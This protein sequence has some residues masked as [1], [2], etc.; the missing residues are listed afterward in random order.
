MNNRKIKRIVLQTV[1]ILLFFA[2]SLS[3]ICYSLGYFE[4]PY[5]ERPGS[6]TYYRPDLGP[7]EESIKGV[8]TG[9]NIS[10][11]GGDVTTGTVIVTVPVETTN[12]GT[13][14]DD[15]T[16]PVSENGLLSSYLKKG[17]KVT[18]ADYDS[19]TKLATV[20]SSSTL[21]MDETLGNTKEIKAIDE[22]TYEDDGVQFEIE[23]I[24]T[25]SRSAVELYMGFIIVDAGTCSATSF[26]ATYDKDGIRTGRTS[27][28]NVK[29]VSIYSSTGSF[30]GTYPSKGLFLAYTRDTSDRALFLIDDVYY[31]LDETSGDFVQSDYV[32]ER[33]NRGLY[34]DYAPNYGK[35]DNNLSIW[36][37]Y[38]TVTLSDCIDTAYAY[39]RYC[40]DWKLAREIYLAN[41]KFAELA[42]SQYRTGKYYNKIFSDILKMEK[43]ILKEEAKTSTAEETTLPTPEETTEVISS[44][45]ITTGPEETTGTD[46]SAVESSAVESSAVESSA[47]ES[48][49]VESSA[50]ESSAVDSSSVDSSAVE[51][52]ATDSSSITTKEE[53]TEKPHVFV[54][55]SKDYELY[56]FTYA[57]KM[58]EVDS[59]ATTTVKFELGDHTKE[60]YTWNSQYKYAKAFNFSE[61]RA[62]T[63]D[64][65]GRIR[66]LKE[67]LGTSVY[68]YRLYKNSVSNANHW[69]YYT[70][71]F[72]KDISSLG[73]YYYD[74]GLLRVRHVE[75]GSY[76]PYV[77]VNDE[78]YLIDTSGNRYELPTGYNLVNYSEG[79]LIL[80]RNGLYGCYHKD[81][82]WIAQPVYTSAEP[83][84]EGL[85]VLTLSD[86]TK[87]MIDKSGNVVIPFRYTVITN[88]SSGV[89]ATYSKDEGWTVLAKVSK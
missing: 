10:S 83:F 24:T 67:N 16:E 54:N 31:Y 20:F 52:S 27:I 38:E 19:G 30:I 87:G 51:S 22:L 65:F 74:E 43:A 14:S 11:I 7:I 72:Y 88:A 4:L 1:T 76:V 37:N 42:A 46:S 2:I 35:S 53:S 60:A 13:P 8:E 3:A 49:A 32:D 21:G 66:I 68:L 57:K 12:G 50:V 41:S 59:S 15:P 47:V 84:V 64:D 5:I 70:E 45:A 58:P 82:Y 62:V 9:E 75:T 25:V 17:Y 63:V 48:S 28:D 36:S 85:C 55:V 26:T 69:E 78:D 33:D 81:G 18:Y 29:A 39:S 77:Y 73:H 61:G 23:S 79:I 86:G 56:R 71:P 6:E 40:A 34:F 44:E 89:I 80:E